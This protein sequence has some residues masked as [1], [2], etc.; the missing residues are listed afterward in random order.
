MKSPKTGEQISNQEYH[1]GNE[2]GPLI[3][4]TRFKAMYTDPAAFR[5]PLPLVGSDALDM[6]TA[7]HTAILDPERMDD[8]MLLP[9]IGFRSNADKDRWR[10]WLLELGAEGVEDV[11]NKDEILSLAR[12]AAEKRGKSIVTPEQLETTRAM[13]ASILECEDAVAA[14]SGGLCERSFRAHGRKA[15]PDSLSGALLSDLKTSS[16][17]ERFGYQAHDLKYPSSLAWYERVLLDCGVRVGAWAWVVI[18][19]VPYRMA[20]D[21]LARHRVKVVVSSM[22]LRRDAIE[23]LGLALERYEECK[24]NDQWPA[25]YIAIEEL[26]SNRY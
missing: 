11:S 12:V 14:L 26:T 23:D 7:A 18:E 15:R 9:D 22:E 8:L 21:G 13:S 4:S 2:W 10:E 1:H 19:S 3:S 20:D 6:G 17:F 5:W 16:K 25:A 24:N